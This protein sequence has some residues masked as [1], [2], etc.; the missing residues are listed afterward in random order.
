MAEESEAKNKPA[1]AAAAKPASKEA[2]HA[3]P[4]TGKEADDLRG[5]LS[6]GEYLGD[7]VIYAPGSANPFQRLTE[8]GQK[9]LDQGGTVAAPEAYT[10]PETF[11]VPTGTDA[12]DD[13]SK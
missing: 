10:M 6:R 5:K 4:I 9:A 1:A 2:G 7:G 13:A 12:D 11:S 3:E 8:A